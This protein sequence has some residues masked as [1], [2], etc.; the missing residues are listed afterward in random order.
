MTKAE[1]VAA[2]RERG[3]PDNWLWHCDRPL[4]RDYINDMLRCANNCGLAPVPL[5]SLDDPEAAW[6]SVRNDPAGD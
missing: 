3:L 6:L 5:R 2:N 4:R 1:R